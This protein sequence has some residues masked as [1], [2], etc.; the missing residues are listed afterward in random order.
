MKG[1]FP[2][3]NG[4]SRAYARPAQTPKKHKLAHPPSTATNA[5]SLI[6]RASGAKLGAMLASG[7]L[8]LLLLSGEE[9][10]IFCGF[11][12]KC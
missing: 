5:R 12:E 2:S 4:A 8:E 10:N 6:L 3:A 1:K 11:V 7:A 9:G